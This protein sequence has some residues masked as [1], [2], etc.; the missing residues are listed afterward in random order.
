MN[1][2]GKSTTFKCLSL[3]EVI[4]GGRIRIKGHE[5]NDLYSQPNLL[6]NMIGYCPQINVIRDGMTVKETIEFLAALK[7]VRTEAI[8]EFAARYAKKFDLFQFF[9]TNAQRLSG[10]NKRKLSTL[11]AMIGNPAIIL[12]DESSAGVD[13]HARRAL[14][15]TIK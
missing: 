13:P 12:L 10:G 4:S 7:G 5:V 11:Q 2:A 8:P 14:W 15:E 1:G 6:R 3:E 9:H